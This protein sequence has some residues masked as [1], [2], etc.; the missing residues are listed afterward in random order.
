MKRWFYR[1]FTIRK[2]EVVVVLLGM[3]G[4]I[5]VI[6]V[7]TYAYFINDLTTKDSIMNRN[8]TGVVLLDR[9]NKPFFT[10]FDAK[11]KQYVS[12][13]DIPETLQF[14]V[15]AS[16]DK[17][18][19]N[20][21]GFS[22]RGIV[23]SVVV[24]LQSGELKSGG[25]TIT[26]QLVKNALL[27]S[28]KDFLRKYQEL[29]LAQEIERRYSKNEILEMYLNSVY[30]GEGAFGAEDASLRY[31]RKHAK[32]LTLGEASLLIAVLPSPSKL[33]PIS[34]NIEQAKKRQKIILEK[35]V[36]FGFIAK[37]NMEQ[38]LAE[39]PTLYDVGDGLNIFGP[40]FAMMVRDE[41]MKQYGEERIAR[42]G[43]KV[44]TTL[45]S[46]WQEFAQ[47]TVERQVQTLARNGVTNGATVVVDPKTGEILAMV[48]SINW[49]NASFGRVN[50]ALAPR[51][52]GSAFKPIV[53][54]K[55]LEE[56]LITPVS[57]LKDEPTTYRFDSQ[58][59]TP[60]NYDRRFRGRVTV[61]RALANSLNVPSVAVLAKLGVPKAIEQAKLLGIETLQNPSSYGLSLVLGA[62]EVKLV[63]LTNAYATF[64]NKGIYNK[65]VSI[66]EIFDKQN[67]VIFK[68]KNNPQA[69]VDEGIAFLVSSI[70]SDNNARQEVFGN[71]L[72]I[73]RPAAVKTGTT[74]NYKDA[75]TI[76]YTPSLAV[77]VWVGNNDGK[78]M[79]S[80]A[81]SLGAAPIWRQLMERFLQETPIERFEKPSNIVATSL[82]FQNGRIVS[83][84]TMSARLEYF[85]EGTEP[86]KA[87]VLA[88][89]SQTQTPS[90]NLSA[91]PLPTDG[92]TIPTISPAQTPKPTTETAKPTPKKPRIQHPVLS[93]TITVPQ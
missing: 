81:G 36:N 12:L 70:L 39:T 79:D 11:H 78:P 53:Y 89:P 20:H 21:P 91:T 83:V 80:V 62:G 67:N 82:C 8:D 64:A 69:V 88:T 48:G 18:F 90:P 4:L 47:D 74:E 15:I 29:V 77:G 86:K 44:K 60:Q 37:E 6:P 7:F 42:Y 23:R 45:K 28:R 34:G 5:L 61:R 54:S 63:E 65:P 14:A 22:I 13:S 10:L 55:A 56:R 87:C 2:S 43:F 46:D 25:S 85:L 72:T 16:E 26:Q 38:A 68:H 84:S 66:L 75:W 52:P 32:D 73:S 33:S 76:G 27:N 93:V 49:Q 58:V 17:E 59:Y 3:T 51:Q 40:H 50:V 35:M 57:I 30:F 19:Y 92:T 24:N 41:L 1:I 9:N 31:F 71:A